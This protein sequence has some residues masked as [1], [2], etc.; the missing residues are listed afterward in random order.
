ML[1]DQSV[2]TYQLVIF[3]WDGTLMDSVPKIVGSMQE[4]ARL[5]DVEPPEAGA[6]KKIIGLGLPEAIQ[7]LFPQLS[8]VRREALR[9]HYSA[10]YIAADAKRCELFAGA[11][12]VLQTLHNM[13]CQLAIATGKSRK[14]LQRVIGGSGLDPLFHYS[15][16]A[17][18]TYSKPH[19]AMV[20]EILS[21]A[22]LAPSQAL[23]VGD[24]EFDMEMAHRAG[25]DRVGVSFGAAEPE[26]LSKY[27]PIVCI[28][29]LEDL[30]YLVKPSTSP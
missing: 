18:E 27:D 8:S 28:D 10:S 9:Q 23:V 15:R 2:L 5:T 21:E 4:A 26:H 20:N 13:G 30:L 7:A 12:H 1:F 6:V 19:P 17:D 14:G 11:E 25:V 22:S 29:A 3:D 16:C 24:S